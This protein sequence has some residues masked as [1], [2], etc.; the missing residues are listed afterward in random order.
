MTPPST[1]AS[2]RPLFRAVARAAVP[3]AATFDEPRWR[4]AETIVDEAL[5]ARPL[6]VRRQVTLFLRVLSVLARLRTGRSL[7]ALP[8]EG[9]RRILASLERAPVLLL[10]RGVWGVRTLAFMGCYGQRATREEIGYRARAEGWDARGGDQGPWPERRGRGAAES[11]TVVEARGEGAT[12]SGG[13]G[14]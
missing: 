11:G 14:A 3:A 12:D 7:A 5:A 4:R 8:P 6:A 2:V 9:A 13:A 1:L 10:R